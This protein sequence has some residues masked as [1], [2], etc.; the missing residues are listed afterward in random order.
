MKEMGIQHGL[1]SEVGSCMRPQHLLAA[2]VGDCRL[3]DPA[4]LPAYMC[5]QSLAL[6]VRQQACIIWPGKLSDQH[7]RRPAQHV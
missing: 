5:E 2:Q 3:T 6:N 7:N 4:A 1:D